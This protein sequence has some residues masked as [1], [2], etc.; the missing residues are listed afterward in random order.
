RSGRGQPLDLQQVLQP[1]DRNTQRPVCVVQVRRSLEARPSLRR[2]GVVKK[3]RMKLPAERTKTALELRRIEVEPP[4][5]PHEREIIAVPPEREDLGALRAEV[6]VDRRAAAAV[7]A[8]L[9]RRRGGQAKLRR[10][11]HSRRSTSRS[12]C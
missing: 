4:R 9:K 8:D 6:P 2:R 11:F 7:T 10:S 5:Q 1:A 12:D 3:I